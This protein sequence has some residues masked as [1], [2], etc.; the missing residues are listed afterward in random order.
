MKKLL[1]I[2]LLTGLTFGFSSAL[3][4]A[5]DKKDKP[6]KVT[7]KEFK[8][9]KDKTLNIDLR[10][11]GGINISGWDKDVV[12]IRA[13]FGGRDWEDCEVSFEEKNG[14]VQINSSYEG[15][16]NGW[17]VH[18]D[19]EIKVPAKYNVSFY[20]MGGGVGLSNIEGRMEG[21]TLGGGLQLDNLKGYVEI[22]TM[23]GG[24]SLTNSEVDG[25]VET[26]G[27]A[28]MI[29]NVTGDIKGHSMGG[30]VSYDN[31]KHRNGRDKN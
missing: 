9:S 28:V 18:C 27:G 11:G 30:P 7:E 15:K 20:T 17:N 25:K 3:G 22:K 1:L 10:T 13:E 29:K 14:G 4:F 16:K 21:K 5:A 19:L 8:T 6:E 12:S 26:M 31:V 23:G 2:S 24:I